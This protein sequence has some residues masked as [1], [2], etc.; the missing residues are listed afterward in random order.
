MIL[1]G[2]KPSPGYISDALTAPGGQ[3]REAVPR[4]LLSIE[5][6]AWSAPLPSHSPEQDLASPLSQ[7]NQDLL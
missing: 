1:V 5:Q 3:S 4:P 6:Q 7:I 2:A